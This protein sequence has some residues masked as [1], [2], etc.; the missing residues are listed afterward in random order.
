MSD[1]EER[2]SLLRSRILGAN[3][4]LSIAENEMESAVAEL[5][6]VLVGDKRLAS[7]GLDRAFRKLKDARGLIAELERMLA[8]ALS[9]PR[10]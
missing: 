6:P 10:T 5:K 9:N 8:T 7:E 2:V 1:L 3:E 4:A